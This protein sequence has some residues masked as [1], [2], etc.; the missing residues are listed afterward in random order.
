MWAVGGSTPLYTELS[1]LIHRG[2]V[3]CN[4]PKTPQYVLDITHPAKF[5]YDEPTV[6]LLRPYSA[7]GGY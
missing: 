5:Y 3:R 4:S 7:I 6:N 1:K 2:T